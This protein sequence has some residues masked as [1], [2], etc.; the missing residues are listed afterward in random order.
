[1]TTP[2]HADRDHASWSAS[3]SSRNFACP[4]AMAMTM[5]LPESTSEAADWGTVCHEIGEICL[6]DGGDADRFIGK[7]MKGKK[8]SFEVDEEMTE[9]TQEYVDYVRGLLSNYE[10]LTGDKAVLML[11]QKFDLSVLGTPFDA[12]GTGDAVIYYPLWRQ[13]DVVDLKTGRGVVVDVVGNKQL[14]T[15]GLGAILHNKGI[16]VDNVTVTIVQTRAA[17][18]DGRIRSETISV[19]DLLDWT[20]DMLAA[21]KLAKEAIDAKPDLAPAAWAAAYLTPGAHCAST[22]CKAAAT[23][24]ALEQKVFDTARLHFTPRN[25]PV[26]SNAKEMT[27]PTE[28]RDRLDLLDMVENWV[29]QVRAHEHW[30]AET[31]QPAEG[32]G[33]VRKV[34]R[35]K[36]DDG[37]DEKVR[38]ACAI[39]G[40]DDE[41]FLKPSVLKTPK[42]VREALKKAGMD[43]LIKDLS[44]TPEGGTNLVRLDKSVRPE[45]G[46]TKISMF[47]PVDK[48]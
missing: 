39:A 27:D 17:H 2:N 30:L 11:E 23:C 13:L 32:Y 8:F 47:S 9:T 45:V 31:G 43:G 28:R 37:A 26:I 44:S 22:F 19:L 42:Q 20:A 5:H 14:R 6:R 12:G 16:K 18:P 48:A 24:P 1:M 40:L 41:K 29:K 46:A 38:Q 34:G 21:M 33:L 10:N 4:G 35:E 7:T 15:Y 36:W 3:A 25:E